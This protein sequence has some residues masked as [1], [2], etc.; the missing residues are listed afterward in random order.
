[1]GENLSDFAKIITGGDFNELCAFI[2][3][4]PLST[5]D[6]LVLIQSGKTDLLS[7]YINHNYIDKQNLCEFV[8]TALSAEQIFRKLK[9]FCSITQELQRA[10][11]ES[12]NE[13]LWALAIDRY[14]FA[15][16]VL[17]QQIKENNQEFLKKYISKR[18]FYLDGQKALIRSQIV[19]LIDQ[20]IQTHGFFREAQ[21]EFLYYLY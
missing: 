21:R 8:K 4:N 17:I 18:A 10:I 3:N 1:M 15:D 16:T 19:D 13:R 6:E 20:Y 5:E 7:F 2:K 14:T 9:D 11:I 12:K